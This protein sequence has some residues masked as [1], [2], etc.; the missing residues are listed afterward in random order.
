MAAKVITF[1]LQKGGCS[2]STSSGITAY[3]LS[4]EYKVLVC[5]LDSQGNITELLTGQDIYDFTGRTILEAMKDEGASAA[6]IKEK[7][8][9]KINDKLDIMTA[10]DFLA[11]F[12]RYVYREYKGNKPSLI[13]SQM[14]DKVKDDYDFVI[15]DTCPALGDATINALGASDAVVI[16]FEPSKFCYS[17]IPRFIE[18][19]G[20]V[21]ELVNPGLKIAGILQTIIDARRTDAKVLMQMLKEEYGDL[22]FDTI[23]QRKAPTGRVS[24]QGFESNPELEQAIQP[25]RDFVKEL[26]ARV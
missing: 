8:V 14:I 4:Q 17:A 20:H 15:V 7:Y 21:Q 25:Y 16:M 22:L 9:H 19:V 3:L 10:E 1:G 26:I 23:I 2:K 5:D 12:P 24:I 18:T 11:T 6:E 13:F